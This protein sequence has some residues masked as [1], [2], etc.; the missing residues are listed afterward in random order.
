MIPYIKSSSAVVYYCFNF[1]SFFTC[2]NVFFCATCSICHSTLVDFPIHCVFQVIQAVYSAFT[3]RRSCRS[4][5][6]LNVTLGH[7]PDIFKA[8]RSSCEQHCLRPAFRMPKPHCSGVWQNV[9]RTLGG[10]VGIWRVG[11]WGLEHSCFFHKLIH[12]IMGA[13]SNRFLQ[14]S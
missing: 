13:C 8:L 9:S 11:V 7:L 5:R 12:E 6:A 4:P 14:L 10:L 3:V 2:C 1:D